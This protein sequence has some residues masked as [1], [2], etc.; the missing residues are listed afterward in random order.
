MKSFLTYVPVSDVILVKDN[1]MKRILNDNIKYYFFGYNS[2]LNRYIP[3]DN[4]AHWYSHDVDYF[5]SQAVNTHM[6]ISSMDHDGDVYRTALDNTLNN[7]SLITTSINNVIDRHFNF[8]NNNNNILTHSNPSLTQDNKNAS[9]LLNTPMLSNHSY[10]SSSSNNP[11][12]SSSSSSP[13]TKI[14]DLTDA[15]INMKFITDHVLNDVN[16]YVRGCTK[17]I[18]SINS[19]SSTNDE[20]I[21]TPSS[22]N[23]DNDLLQHFYQPLRLGNNYSID[24]GDNNDIDSLL[25]SIDEKLFH[26]SRTDINQ[27]FSSLGYLVN[28]FHTVDHL[29]Q[30]RFQ[31]KGMGYLDGLIVK[32]MSQPPL[33][34]ALPLSS[35]SSSS[36]TKSLQSYFRIINYLEVH[37][38]PSEDAY[39]DVMNEVSKHPP[40]LYQVGQ[41]VRHKIYGYHG[42]IIGFEQVS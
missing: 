29:L 9:S 22:T 30:L 18:E 38:I 42:V 5:N 28:C 26:Y 23:D 20:S 3:N 14:G 2:L 12:L 39:C 40:A 33:L 36:S 25:S 35:S 15:Q 7:M 27:I 41:V 6:I 32:S 31:S 13:F 21:N 8:G 34:P 10:P 37:D 17:A 24:H 19:P 1:N 4:L 11:S 16:Y